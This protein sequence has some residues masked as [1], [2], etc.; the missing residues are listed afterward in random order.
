M[1]LI[2]VFTPTYNRAETL[3]RTY[4][5]LCLQTDKDFEWLIIDDG[6]KDDTQSFVEKWKYENI[7][8]I[9][10]IYQ[11][12]GGLHTGYNTAF[13]NISTELNVC[14]DSDDYMPADAIAN[15]KKAWRACDNKESLAGIIGLD[16]FMD[17]TPIGGLF[18]K[19]GDFHIY[20]MTSFHR[21][22]TKIVCRT[23]ILKRFCPMPVYAGEKNFNPIYYYVQ[24]DKNYKFCLV[25]ENLCYVDYQQTGMSANIFKQ[26]WNSPRSFAQL[27]RLYMSMPYYTIWQHFRNAIH[28][29]SSCIFSK[30]WNGIATSPKPVLCVFAIPF[31]I[32]L[33][34]YIRYKC[35]ANK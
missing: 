2:T 35:K 7:I 24:V 30:Q 8:P 11:K 25:N 10:Y 23:D 20:E 5:S 34:I 32:A 15:I 28:Y 18:K 12:N 22:D 21:G 33:N 13:A 26:Y 31:G 16:Y 6:S 9:R 27:R 17:D 14:V 1:R 29:V 19:T 3:K 4:R